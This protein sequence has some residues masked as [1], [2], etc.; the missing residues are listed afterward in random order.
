MYTHTGH[1]TTTNGRLFLSDR[2]ERHCVALD[3]ASHRLQLHFGTMSHTHTHIDTRQTGRF[4]RER[5]Q[6][7]SQS[8]ARPGSERIERLAR[9]GVAQMSDVPGSPRAGGSPSMVRCAR[10]ERGATGGSRYALTPASSISFFLAGT[11]LHAALLATSIHFGTPTAVR[12]VPPP[13][14]LDS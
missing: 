6:I 2:Q 14:T 3:A 11:A 5:N 13:K 10:T 12:V 7:A 9:P 1:S 4:E 8:A